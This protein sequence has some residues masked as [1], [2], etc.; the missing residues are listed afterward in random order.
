MWGVAEGYS[1][2]ELMVC[3]FLLQ[4]LLQISIL[5]LKDKELAEITHLDEAL[6]SFALW[7]SL[8]QEINMEWIVFITNLETYLEVSL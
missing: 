8:Q 7:L 5:I 4:I 2:E 3:G 1:N 6:L